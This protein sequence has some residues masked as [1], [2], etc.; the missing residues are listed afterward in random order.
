MVKKQYSKKEREQLVL[1]YRSSGKTR[2]E[3]CEENRIGKSTFSNW[4][5]HIKTESSIN[6]GFIPVEIISEKAGI[7]IEI[8]EFKVKIEDN[9][10][11]IQLQNVMKALSEIC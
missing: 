11:K 10:S 5:K 6:P 2:T 1:E 8:G 3:W 7:V 9:F 4:L